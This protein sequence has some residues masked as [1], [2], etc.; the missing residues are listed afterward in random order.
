MVCH[1]QR[2]WARLSF[3]ARPR[4]ALG[5]ALRAERG[6]LRRGPRGPPRAL[7]GEDWECGSK[8]IAG[9][10]HLQGPARRAE[11]GGAGRVW[12]RGERLG[13]ARLLS[14]R[15]QRRSP[16]LLPGAA[17]RGAGGGRERGERAERV[18][19]RSRRARPA[20]EPRSRA[21]KPRA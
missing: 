11:R 12:V 19:R 17:R 6:G 15:P 18:P 10:A 13:G 1:P 21:S 2:T 7:P 5:H 20:V 4:L 14:R 8:F 16:W 9:P 3:K